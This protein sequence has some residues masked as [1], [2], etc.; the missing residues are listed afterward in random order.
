MPRL[1][2]GDTWT[3]AWELKDA[4]G[5][6][7]LDWWEYATEVDRHHPLVNTISVRRS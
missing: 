2:R 6:D 1:Y 5:A 7:V 4:A 3:R